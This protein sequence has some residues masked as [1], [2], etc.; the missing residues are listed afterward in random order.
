MPNLKRWN[1]AVGGI[2]DLRGVAASKAVKTVEIIP[3]IT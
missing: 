1:I 3:C 2:L